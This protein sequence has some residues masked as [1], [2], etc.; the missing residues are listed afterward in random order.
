MPTIL[1]VE[2]GDDFWE[3][4]PTHSLEAFA[5]EFAEEFAGNFIKFAS[6]I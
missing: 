3:T 2:F 6:P 4:R 5:E 1:G